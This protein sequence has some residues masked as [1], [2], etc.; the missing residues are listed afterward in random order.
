[1][2]THRQREMLKQMQQRETEAEQ[3]R[4]LKRRA[5]LRF[6]ELIHPDADRPTQ[7]HDRKH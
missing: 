3:L 5:L 6:A 4:Q 7:V 1:M 2:I